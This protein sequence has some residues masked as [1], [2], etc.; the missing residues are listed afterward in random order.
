MLVKYTP[1]NKCFLEKYS[2]INLNLSLSQ[3]NK[4]RSSKFYHRYQPSPLPSKY[5]YYHVRHTTKIEFF[6]KF[7]TQNEKIVYY[8]YIL[9]TSKQVNTEKGKFQEFSHAHTHFRP[10]TKI[11]FPPNRPQ[12]ACQMATSK[13]K[14]TQK[15]SPCNL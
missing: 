4:W 14:T 9:T 8:Y 3:R 13:K 1:S 11:S 6:C 5:I 2:T 12:Y 15:Y 10:R 7:H